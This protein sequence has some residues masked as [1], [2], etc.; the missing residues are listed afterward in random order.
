MVAQARSTES[1]MGDICTTEAVP[2]PPPPPA[3]ERIRRSVAK[4]ISWRVVGTLD[5]LVLSFPVLTFLGPLFGAEAASP[6]ENARTSSFIAMTE[7]VTK[8]VLFYLHERGWSRLAWGVV[9][10]GARRRELHRRSVVKTAS[11][12]VIA[13]IDTVLLALIFTGS[14]AAALSI[15][16][17]EVLTKLAL[18]F[19]HERAWQ[20]IGWGL[21]GPRPG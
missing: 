14:P 16:G 5:T 15:G 2:G 6:A 10:Q 3:G 8:I 18:Y 1:A 17:L 21:G 12:R 19:G 13:G 11:W 7:L 4:A 20:R 9:A